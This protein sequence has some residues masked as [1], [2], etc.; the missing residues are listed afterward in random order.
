MCW[1]IHSKLT[2][3]SKLNVPWY[4]YIISIHHIRQHYQRYC[5]KVTNKRIGCQEKGKNNFIPWLISGIIFGLHLLV[6]YKTMNR[7]CKVKWYGEIILN[8]LGILKPTAIVLI[9]TCNCQDIGILFCYT[10]QSTS[11]YKDK[12]RPNNDNRCRLVVFSLANFV[13]FWWLYSDIGLNL[14]LSELG[15]RKQRLRR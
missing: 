15:Y 2:W 6:R 4:H 3:R 10:G 11:N 7:C 5:F 9:I 12:Q 1:V 14:E 8:G 13:S